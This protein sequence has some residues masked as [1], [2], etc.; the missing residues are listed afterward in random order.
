MTL[1]D[2]NPEKKNSSLSWNVSKEEGMR[3]AHTRSIFLSIL[4]VAPMSV[5]I[6]TLTGSG[7][8]LKINE[9]MKTTERQIIQHCYFVNVFFESQN[10]TETHFFSGGRLFPKHC[11]F[12]KKVKVGMCFSFAFLFD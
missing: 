1:E 12:L 2:P 4:R 10:V 7:N 11:I 5:T 3:F 8:S 6:A 9:C